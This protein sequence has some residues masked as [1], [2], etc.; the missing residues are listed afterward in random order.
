MVGT[1]LKSFHVF[2]K[3]EFQNDLQ[4]LCHIFFDFLYLGVEVPLHLLFELGEQKVVGELI[5]GNMANGRGLWHLFG[6]KNAQFL[7]R[8][9]KEHCH[10]RG[11]I[12]D[13]ITNLLHN[14]LWYTDLFRKR[15]TTRMIVF[16]QCGSYT[17]NVFIHSCCGRATISH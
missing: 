10:A 3:C 11:K 5:F 12:P 13:L 8:Y 17:S 1:I 6:P 9:M 14:C 16:F 15:P 7:L 4:P 2:G